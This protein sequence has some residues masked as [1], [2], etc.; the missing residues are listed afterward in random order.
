MLTGEASRTLSRTANDSM[1]APSSW[2]GRPGPLWSQPAHARVWPRSPASPRPA[3]NRSPHSRVASSRSSG[4][5]PPSPLG[6]AVSSSPS[7]CSSVGPS[8]TVHLRHRRHRRPRPRGTAPDRHALARV[9]RRADGQAADP[10]QEPPIRRDAGLDDL[11]LHGQDGDADAQRDGGG[12]GL[13]PDRHD[14]RERGRLEPER[15]SP[16]GRPRPEFASVLVT[17]PSRPC[18][19]RPDTP[20][21]RQGV[22]PP[23]RP[24]RGGLDVFHAGSASTRTPTGATTGPSC[25]FH[26][27][28]EPAGWLSSSTGQR[29]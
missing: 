10:R 5:S 25:V 2:K 21:G 27:I 12:G 6:S 14:V 8:R 24:D 1:R 3:R 23:R 9:G 29:S 15:R 16:R 18:D 22:A 11:H 20:S 28:P 13:D 26:S 19:A 4:S 7:P 17:S